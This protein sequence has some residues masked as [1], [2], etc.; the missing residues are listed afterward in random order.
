MA[1]KLVPIVEVFTDE[2]HVIYV[3]KTIKLALMEF[4]DAHMEHKP[5]EHHVITVKTSEGWIDV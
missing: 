5:F 4:V 3:D 2:F 1:R